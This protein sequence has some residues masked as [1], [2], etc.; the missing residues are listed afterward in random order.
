MLNKY[1]KINKFLYCY[2]NYLNLKKCNFEYRENGC[3]FEYENDNAVLVWWG[4]AAQAPYS[5]C[6]NKIEK[7]I[8]NN[9]K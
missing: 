8:V 1:K 2:K 5:Y 9:F 4:I 6:I 3:Y 7:Y